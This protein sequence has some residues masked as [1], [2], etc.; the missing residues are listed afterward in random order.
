MLA[1]RR[2]TTLPLMTFAESIDPKPG[3]VQWKLGSGSV[4]S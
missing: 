3:V 2:I 1:E 4:W